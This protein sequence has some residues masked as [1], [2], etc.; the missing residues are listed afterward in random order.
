MVVVGG[1]KNGRVDADREN[2]RRSPSLH[3]RKLETRKK[4]NRKRR[5]RGIG[6]RLEKSKSSKVKKFRSRRGGAERVEP[7]EAV[8]LAQA[9]RGLRIPESK[10]DK[11]YR[12]IEF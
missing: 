1:P 7:S 5:S 11:S 4:E 6:W 2:G 9:K 10:L 12:S 8:S 3:H